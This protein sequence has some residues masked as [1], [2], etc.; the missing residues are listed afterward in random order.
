MNPI[1][2]IMGQAGLSQSAQRQGQ[3][4]Q[5][6]MERAAQDSV[7]RAQ[8][9][10][11]GIQQ[12]DPFKVNAYVQDQKLIVNNTAVKEKTMFSMYS[13]MKDYTKKHSDLIFTVLLVMLADKWFFKGTFKQAITDMVAK[14][15]DKAHKLTD[16]NKT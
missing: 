1:S 13:L 8:M 4:A 3:L 10:Q 16:E 5:A 14:L 15:I 6:Q 12:Y 11:A 7:Y 2:A 9:Q